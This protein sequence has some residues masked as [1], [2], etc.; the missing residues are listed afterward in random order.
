MATTRRAGKLRRLAAKAENGMRIGLILSGKLVA[1]RATRKA[2][3]DTGRLKRSIKEGKPYKVRKGALGIDIGTNVKYAR[4]QEMG[5]GLF[6]EKGAKK[7]IEIRPKNK[8]ALSF[9]WPN[10]PAGLTPSSSG[11]YVFSKVMH[12]GVRAQPYLRPALAESTNEIKK[13]I[14]RSVVGAI[15]RP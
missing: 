13:I 11:K 1:Q 5:S 12:P 10:A 7:K 9:Y 6:A 15:T 8:K 2:P 3:R 4:A 14:I